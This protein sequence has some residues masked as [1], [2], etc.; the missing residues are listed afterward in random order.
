MFPTAVIFFRK[1]GIHMKHIRSQFVPAP[2]TVN[3]K[4][5]SIRKLFSL[6]L[7]VITTI[8]NRRFVPPAEYILH[9]TAT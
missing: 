8:Y 7:F 1:K 3:D 5:N 6:L 2:T 4:K 9:S